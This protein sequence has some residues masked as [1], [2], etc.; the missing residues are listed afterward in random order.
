MPRD[1]N[2][3]WEEDLVFEIGVWS[4]K[5]DLVEVT[6]RAG[7]AAGTAGDPPPESAGGSRDQPARIVG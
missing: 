1:S 7:G 4:P 3:R 5:G 2:Q 6:A